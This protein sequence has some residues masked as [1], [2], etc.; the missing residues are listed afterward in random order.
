MIAKI[1][2]RSDK[3]DHFNH[4]E[5]SSFYH[6]GENIIKGG[7]FDGCSTGTNSHFASQLFCYAFA[8]WPFVAIPITSDRVVNDIYSSIDTTADALGLIDLQLLSTVVVFDFDKALKTLSLRIFGDAIYYVN[9]VEYVVDQGNKP[10]YMGYHINKPPHEFKAYI[11]KYPIRVYE[12]VESFSICSD[13]LLSFKRSNMEAEPPKF[14]NPIEH[15]LQ[16]PKGKTALELRMNQLKRDKYTLDDDL[17]I[18]SYVQDPQ[19]TDN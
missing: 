3:Y 10:D 9:G 17:S 2:Q 7:I 14:P 11:S 1:S 6:E 5:D 15:M 8:N 12:D 4:C 18:I 13:G 16:P 19:R